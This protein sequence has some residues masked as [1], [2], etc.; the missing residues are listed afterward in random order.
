MIVK[1]RLR[2]GAPC[3]KVSTL[4]LQL[5]C[6]QFA[7]GSLTAPRVN[8]DTSPQWYILNVAT[9]KELLCQKLL[10]L[11]IEKDN[12]QSE[13]LDVVV[14]CLT[15]SVTRGKTTKAMQKPLYPSYC[16]VN[17]IMGQVRAASHLLLNHP[18]IIF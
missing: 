8:E 10:D 13:V 15:T 4:I 18:F 7:T 17:M 16:F 14:P 5:D 3:E 1:H 12:L 6:D 2:R 9:G 11:V